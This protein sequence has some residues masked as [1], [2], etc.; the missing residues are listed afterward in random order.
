[1]NTIINYITRAINSVAFW[2]AWMVIPFLMEFIPA[3]RSIFILTIRRHK[4]RKRSKMKFCPD[5]T[6][7]VP[8]YNS[9]KTLFRCLQS[10]N[11]STYDNQHIKVLLVNNS[12]KTNHDFDIYAKAQVTLPTLKIQW[13]KSKQGKSKALNMALYNSE[14]KYIINVDSDG[15]FD[16]N[17]I[18]NMIEKF[19]SDPRI[20]CMTG[21]I[22]TEP[23]LINKEHGLHKLLCKL[24]FYE[25]AQAFL[26]GR[27][28]AA[29]HNDIYTLSGAFSAFK[30]D[31]ILSSRLYNTETICEDT[32]MTFQ[33]KY[34]YKN[35]VEICEDAIF[36]VDPIEDINKLYT[37]RQRWQRGSL[38]VSKLF[39]D[40]FDLKH[41][42]TDVNV[43]TVLY[44]HTFAFPRAIWY[45]VTLY[46]ITVKFSREILI[47]TSMLIYLLYVIMAFAYWINAM[48]YMKCVKDTRQF[49]R[50]NI[51][52]LALMP[53]FN[54]MVFFFRMAGIINSINTNSAWK[55]K[56]F[57]DEATAVRDAIRKDFKHET[58]NHRT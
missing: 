50:K 23:D 28:Y 39:A 51:F 32:Q 35:N 49:Y 47:T 45:V 44:D 42:L 36:Y 22:L 41:T 15:I 13:L 55:T 53:L 30:K 58:K 40:K 6:I 11:D 4:Y 52:C 33:M 5:I 14:G 48:Q 1:M 56:N 24:E 21:T 17:A 19:E 34:L 54:L 46:F 43:R 26:A 18:F 31:A 12:N 16:K 2:G 57:K 10:I 25:Y 20:E 38:E 29:E 9:E 7:I 27:S 8:V 3:I 37:Q